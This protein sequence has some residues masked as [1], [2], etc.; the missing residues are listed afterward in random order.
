MNWLILALVV[1]LI[2]NAML[3]AIVVPVARVWWAAAKD[4]ID[5]YDHRTLAARSD[6]GP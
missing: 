6:V 2:L 5:S 4:E 3:L 1:S